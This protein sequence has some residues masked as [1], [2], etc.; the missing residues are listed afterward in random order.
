MGFL[1]PIIIPCVEE[2]EKEEIGAR[3]RHIVKRERCKP[4]LQMS[5]KSR[6]EFWTWED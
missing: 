4:S 2:E 6:T 1:S 3:E 5:D